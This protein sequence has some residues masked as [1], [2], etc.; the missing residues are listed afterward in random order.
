MIPLVLHLTSILRMVA[1]NLDR[2]PTLTAQ[3]ASAATEEEGNVSF[4]ENTGNVLREAFNKCIQ[5]ARPTQPPTPNSLSS[6]LYLILNSCMSLYNRA[7]K[8]RNAEF[9]LGTLDKT[10]PPLSYYPASQRVTYLY[11]LGKFHFSSNHFCRAI[12][13]LQSAYDQCAKNSAC[14][15]Q[16]RLILIHLIAAGLCVGRLPNR[17]L[18][19]DQAAHSISKPF[20]ELSRIIRS[21][22]IGRFHT[23]LDYT[24]P[25][26]TSAQWFLRMGILLQL[27]NRCEI[28]CWR[29]LILQAMRHA[30]FLGSA[31]RQSSMPYVRFTAISD[32]ATFSYARARKQVQMS[33][34][35]QPQPNGAA[36]SSI[37]SLDEQDNDYV[38]PDFADGD[39]NDQEDY[40]NDGASTPGF[41]QS[42]HADTDTASDSD[43]THLPLPP[44][45]PA[46]LNSVMLSLISQ[47][48]LKGF[49]SHTYPDLLQSR[50]AIPGIR[51]SARV[52]AAAGTGPQHA[53]REV[54]F[55]SVWDVV[56][57]GEGEAGADVPGWMTEGKVRR[58]EEERA[59]GGGG[60]VIRITGAKPAGMV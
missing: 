17:I 37:V 12:T 32:A 14:L 57:E 43:A 16:R 39:E 2:D 6:G 45:T 11:F 18:I 3:S 54:G 42:P 34:E 5:R 51:A 49:V 40:D 58:R 35:S 22:N 4:V 28:L 36:A 8:L 48:F 55:P 30:G 53:W 44:P 21:G 52:A 59:S 56:R 7:G 41:G 9:L 1:I 25:D 60:R 27:R 38:D 19:V 47:G 20:L 29:S 23:Y 33:Q 15:K 13:T 26:N 10:S 24:L 31:D 50:F 46:E